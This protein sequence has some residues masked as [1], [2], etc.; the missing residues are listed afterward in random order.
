M[1]QANG[2]NV[3]GLHMGTVEEKKKEAKKEKE[4]ILNIGQK[5]KKVSGFVPRQTLDSKCKW[6]SAIIIWRKYLRRTF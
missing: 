4:R 1:Q 6:I 2:N 3:K 5:R